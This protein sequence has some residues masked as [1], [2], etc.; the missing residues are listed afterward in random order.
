MTVYAADN[1]IRIGGLV[2][3]PTHFTC[4]ATGVKLTLKSCTIFGEGAEKDVYVK[5]KQ[6]VV[7]PTA[8]S[9]RKTNGLIRLEAA[10]TSP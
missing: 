9:F 6:P 5:G 4:K 10:W 3:M 1:P 7:K 8:V 2:F